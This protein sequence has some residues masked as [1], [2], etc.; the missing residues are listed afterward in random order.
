MVRVNQW[1]L[2]AVIVVPAF[3]LITAIETSSLMEI[4]VEICQGELAL[5]V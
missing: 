3:I 1:K 5:D 2:T 4:D